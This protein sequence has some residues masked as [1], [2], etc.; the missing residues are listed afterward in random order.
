NVSYQTTFHFQKKSGHRKLPV[1]QTTEKSQVNEKKSSGKSD[2]IDIQNRDTPAENTRENHKTPVVSATGNS[3]NERFRS[4]RR[5]RTKKPVHACS[6]SQNDDIQPSEVSSNASYTNTNTFSRQDS[7]KK[8]EMVKPQ[9][10]HAREEPTRKARTLPTLSFSQRNKISSSDFLKDKK[11]LSTAKN[12]AQEKPAHLTDQAADK[13]FLS[14]DSFDDVYKANVS[15]MAD[16]RSSQSTVDINR[17]E[18]RQIGKKGIVAH[19]AVDTGKEQELLLQKSFSL[20]EEVAEC[21]KYE[22][23]EDSSCNDTEFEHVKIVAINRFGEN[24]KVDGALR[25]ELQGSGSWGS[26]VHQKQKPNESEQLLKDENHKTLLCRMPSDASDKLST[27]TVCSGSTLEEGNLDESSLA[28]EDLHLR[29]CS[30]NSS[31]S[32]SMFRPAN[33][34]SLEEIEPDVFP[35]S[36]QQCKP[37]LVETDP[38][39][40]RK[41]E[42]P[43]DL[44]HPGPPASDPCPGNVQMRPPERRKG[45]R[46]SFKDKSGE[47][48][49]HRNEPDCS[50]LAN[51]EDKM[52]SKTRSAEEK[53]IPQVASEPE[54]VT[55]LSLSMNIQGQMQSIDKSESFSD[56]PEATL[57]LDH[58]FLT[59]ET[60][61]ISELVKDNDSTASNSHINNTV[62]RASTPDQQQRSLQQSRQPSD[63]QLA[64]PTI[65]VSSTTGIEKEQAED[66]DLD[67]LFDKH[68][69]HLLGSRSSLADSRESIYSVYSDAGEVNYGKIPVTGDI[70][71]N[72]TY[73][74]KSSTLEVHVKQCRG[75]AA[76]DT[77]HNKSDPYV[78]TYLL[79]DK[80]RSGKR[81]TKIK[82]HTLNPT[83][84]EVLKHIIGFDLLQY[85]ITR[86]ELESRTLWVTVWHNDRL[87]RND[88]LGE[89]T[90]PL[91]YYRFEESEPRWYPLQ[92]RAVGQESP[93]MAYKGD[94]F[95]S[96]KYVPAD[97]V[98]N[99]PKKKSGSLRK[100]S[101]EKEKTP[102]RLGEVHIFIKEAQN[103]T[104]MRASAGSNPFCKGRSSGKRVDASNQEND[105]PQVAAR[106]HLFDGVDQSQLHL[107]GLELTIWD[108]EKL[109]SNDFLGGV[110]LNLGQ[111]SNLGNGK[112]VDWMDARGEEVEAWQSMIEHPNEWVDAQLPLR[113]SMGKQVVKK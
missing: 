102:A 28:E 55:L 46:V 17:A 7:A 13:S 11:N 99:A 5:S 60:P 105:Q 80:T 106:S 36:K 4:L 73:N 67:D 70:M 77:K 59:H 18:S 93:M 113:A 90:I 98:D 64:V 91:D 86:S 75:L 76:V 79:P 88:F 2:I 19:A 49:L 112:P 38:V 69:P 103:L 43:H 81:K 83:F 71:F 14:S 22:G 34:E 54:K 48:V 68:H 25:N 20:S 51:E 65:A 12:L 50:P 8:S 78:K 41:G 108:H 85:S 87:G 84:D 40:R 24:E 53:T 82:K 92:E 89:L 56:L 44:N 111:G 109:S 31:V 72:L 37:N 35:D 96:L 52:T 21:L 33:S 45:K 27:S 9:E 61:S 47:Q 100:K 26:Q 39:N 95:V 16:P 97:M 23:V 29:E 74:V 63:V 15:L 32:E 57:D 42:S 10:K 1:L 110:R 107:H 104:A 101:K 66:D 3:N 94:L 62:I 6:Q 30:P 58:D